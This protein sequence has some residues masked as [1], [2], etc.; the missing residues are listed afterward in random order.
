M[1]SEKP[2]G[3]H[4]PKSPFK[5]GLSG[6]PRLNLALMPGLGERVGVHPP[7]EPCYG[8]RMRGLTGVKTNMIPSQKVI[9]AVTPAKAGVQN[10]LFFLDS[11]FR[12]N[13]RGGHFPPFYEYIKYGTLNI[14]ERALMC[15]FAATAPRA[16]ASGSHPRSGT[17][18][19]RVTRPRNPL[20]SYARKGRCR[21]EK[22]FHACASTS[23]ALRLV[24][25]TRHKHFTH[26]STLQAEVIK[27][28]HRLSFHDP[29]GLTELHRRVM[30]L[31]LSGS[32]RTP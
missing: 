15:A 5:G 20:S 27:K 18:T 7:Q 6:N 22:F 13:D 29:C 31:C 17:A 1:I 2:G 16:C 23:V 25:G 4:P 24:R 30:P 8:G 11:G 3:K 14:S 19:C 28:G 9:K 26:F 12:R 21:R 10:Y 32:R